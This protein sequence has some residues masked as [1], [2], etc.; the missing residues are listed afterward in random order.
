MSENDS[1]KTINKIQHRVKTSELVESDILEFFTLFETDDLLE[2]TKTEDWWCGGILTFKSQDLK[3]EFFMPFMEQVLGNHQLRDFFFEECH[4]RISIKDDSFAEAKIIEIFLYEVSL[5]KLKSLCYGIKEQ[6]FNLFFQLIKKIV[7]QRTY[8]SDFWPYGFAENIDK[9]FSPI[10]KKKAS[11]SIIDENFDEILFL[12]NEGFL[13]SLTLIDYT[14]LILDPNLDFINFIITKTS[15]RNDKY[16]LYENGIDFPGESERISQFI[17]KKLM[18]I[19]NELNDQKID[20]LI[21]LCLHRFIHF[22]DFIALYHDVKKNFYVTAHK[23]DCYHHEGERK[24]LDWQLGQLKYLESGYIRQFIAEVIKNGVIEEMRDL[25]RNKW[26]S[27]LDTEDFLSLWDDPEINL[28]DVALIINKD[29]NR[30][31]YQYGIYFQ[32]GVLKALSSKFGEKIMET[33]KKGDEKEIKILFLL[34]FFDYLNKEEISIM[35]EDLKFVE[36]ICKLNRNSWDSHEADKIHEFF[37]KYKP[38]ISLPLKSI[39]INKLENKNWGEIFKIWDYG[40]LYELEEGDLNNLFAEHGVSLIECI[41]KSLH[42]IAYEQKQYRFDS[43]IG[44]IPSDYKELGGVYKHI[45]KVD[46]NL[47]KEQVVEIIKKQD[48]KS[49]VPLVGAYF[50]NSLEPKDIQELILDKENGFFK[51]IIK[52]LGDYD[53]ELYYYNDDFYIS[54]LK[55]FEICKSLNE[56][57]IKYL[58]LSVI[59]DRLITNYESIITEGLIEKFSYSELIR[60]LDILNIERLEAFLISLTE[61]FRYFE[62]IICHESSRSMMYFRNLGKS[63]T[64]SL[65]E[66]IIQI[67]KNSKFSPIYFSIVAE[68]FLI[69]IW[70]YR[71]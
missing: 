39:I 24:N 44:I 8:S 67:F 22:R 27:L 17:S 15:E 6:F 50:L 37:R 5:E 29:L 59:N 13:Q 69:N 25:F 19:L 46:K 1:T 9:I 70:D 14:H 47:I 53:D 16:D 36:L 32:R 3:L 23:H 38:L 68:S 61:A 33:V 64:N 26:F 10:V 42:F 7:N 66:K 12:S 54:H 48:L 35:M 40:Y 31:W 43:Q 30:N 63:L 71:K 60:I 45:D 41:L 58:N 52:V 65:K 56:D 2:Y 57:V 21:G 20:A 34:E 18:N 49:L 4:R 11:D 62:E 28:Y 55:F 51:N